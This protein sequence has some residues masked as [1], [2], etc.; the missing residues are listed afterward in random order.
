MKKKIKNKRIWR[1]KNE[2]KKK[3]KKKTQKTNVALVTYVIQN[4]CYYVWKVNCV[5]FF[6]NIYT[7]I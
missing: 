7:K 2:K 1:K 5:H 3:K 6:E 4:I